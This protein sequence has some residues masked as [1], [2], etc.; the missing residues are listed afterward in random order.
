MANQSILLSRQESTTQCTCHYCDLSCTSIT[1]YCLPTDHWKI[2][3]RNT[4]VTL[5]G[6]NIWMAVRIDAALYFDK[7]W[8][9]VVHM[10][11]TLG[12]CQC[13]V[14]RD[15]KCQQ[16]GHRG[17]EVRGFSLNKHIGHALNFCYML[18]RRNSSSSDLHLFWPWQCTG[19][20]TQ[21]NK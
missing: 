19:M 16:R 15:V 4:D 7:L 8:V 18:R 12:C 14:K 9:R 6:M 10:C 13:W 20:G 1:H 3:Q 21:H 11:S 5:P 2:Y 17:P